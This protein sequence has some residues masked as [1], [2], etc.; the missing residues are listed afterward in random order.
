MA[1]WQWFQYSCL[2]SLLFWWVV[3]IV[4]TTASYP[5]VRR[6]HTWQLKRR[7]IESQ[8]RHLENPQNAEARFQ[9]AN[10]YAEGRSWRK[11]ARYA[12]EAVAAARENPLYDGRVPYHFLR[13][14]GDALYR[15][16][17]YAEAGEAY[18]EAL[19]AKSDLGHAEAVF[20]L[21]KSLYGRG[22][23]P[24]ALDAFREAVKENASNLEGYFRLAQAA[25]KLG[26]ADEAA[27]TRE[28]FWRVAA[29]LP[30]FARQRR[31]RWRLAFL[32]FPLTR[33]I[34]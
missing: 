25:T 28:E 11:A 8:G 7:F 18:S 6:F 23:I 4:V 22:K 3:I 12:R 27:R 16:R 29:S 2:G 1:F 24:G 14:L 32:L 26:K 33:F 20:G 10:I 13:L 5:L 21:G 30:R 34:V 19:R 15:R 17:E 31:L 9:L